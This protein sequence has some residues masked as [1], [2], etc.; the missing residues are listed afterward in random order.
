M[1]AGLIALAT[2]AVQAQTYAVR[3]EIVYTMDGEPIRDGVV[4]VKD[5]KIE[6]VGAYGRVRIPDGYEVTSAKV[7]TPGFI[8]A[9]SVVGLA[10][11]LNQPHDQDQLDRSSAFQPELRALDA[12][13]AREELV[14]FLREHGV[15][16]LHTGHGPGALASGQTMLVKTTGE[17]VNE[18][19]VDSVWGVAFTLGRSVSGNYTNPGSRS[20]AMAMLRT[21]FLKAQE[22]AKKENPARD[23]RMEIMGDVL[24]GRV[25]AVFTVHGATEIQSALRLQRE[26][27]FDLVL[28]GASEAHLVIDEIKAA[29]VPVI[30]HPTMIRPGGEAANATMEM[31]AILHRNGIPFAF[32]SGFEGY[33]PK[34]RVVQFEAGV[35]AANGLPVAAALR[36]LTLGGAEL[37]GIADRVGSLRAGKDADIALFDGDPL[38]YTTHTVGVMINGRWVSTAT[39]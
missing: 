34:T 33:V 11:Y 39:R 15:T 2:V 30:V 9:H 19:L 28:D 26:F 10:G 17:T 16:T 1:T 22:Y 8:D 29:R 7:V 35:A 24:A 31:A 38:E 25:K 32:Q 3:G 23:L 20:R 5:G 27:G 36:A 6:R 13:N 4:L 18:A 21:E 12:Y 37:L 14:V